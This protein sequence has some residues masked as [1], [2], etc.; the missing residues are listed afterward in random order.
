MPVVDPAIATIIADAKA[1]AADLEQTVTRL[2]PRGGTAAERHA[3][4]A[5]TRIDVWERAFGGVFRLLLPYPELFALEEKHGPLGQLY[6][7]LPA[8]GRAAAGRATTVEAARAVVGLGLVGGGVGVMDGERVTITPVTAARLVA[9][10]EDAPLEETWRLARAV[11]LTRLEGRPASD[12]EVA[13]WTIN[14]QNVPVVPD[15]AGLAA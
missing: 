3:R 8:D 6:G 9:T 5:K 10:L 11:L 1:R 15:W 7:G 4:M 2:Q 13:A 14:E 12:A